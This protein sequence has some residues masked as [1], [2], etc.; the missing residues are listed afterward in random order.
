MLFCPKWDFG[1]G[2]GL[3]GFRLITPVR[4]K[5]AFLQADSLWARRRV[6]ENKHIRATDAAVHQL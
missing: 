6:L 1:G 3:G 2:V 4:R 5:I